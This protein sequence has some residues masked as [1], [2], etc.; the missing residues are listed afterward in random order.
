MYEKSP[1]QYRESLSSTAS[2]GE[3]ILN[4]TA[5]ASSGLTNQASSLAEIDIDIDHSFH[6]SYHRV[7]TREANVGDLHYHIDKKYANYAER[8]RMPE[9]LRYLV[10]FSDIRTLLEC[11]FSAINFYETPVREGDFSLEFPPDISAWLINCAI[12]RNVAHRVPHATEDSYSFVMALDYR[13]GM[14]FA[15]LKAA[16]ARW[17]KARMSR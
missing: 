11:L 17:E 13:I 12:L 15:I 14:T 9:A 4:T 1:L 8:I 6:F 10:H 2:R 7:N 5:T 16:Y 3:E